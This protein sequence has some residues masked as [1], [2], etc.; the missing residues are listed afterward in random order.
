L[1]EKQ[2]FENPL[3][4]YTRSEVSLPLLIGDRVLGAL[5]VQST[6]TADFGIGVIET[7]ENMASQ[8]AIALE[9]ARLFQ[10]AQNSINELHS[11]QKQ[12]LLKGWSS[13]K[14][15]ND[16]LEYSV[17]EPTDAANQI[18][19][20]AIILRDQSLGKITLERS[21]EWS[22]EQQSLVDAVTAQAAI[23]LENARL[24]SES[25]QIALRERTLSEIN[26]KIWSSTSI[27]SILQTVVKELG[28]RLDTAN[29]TIELK[30][31]DKS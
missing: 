31:D 18:L 5:N 10:E 26:S 24:V 15:Y 28:K 12:Y 25:R 13:I 2:R 21:D 4:P 23:A 7:M 9:N 17:G 3:L 6:K 8:V 1:D 27:E 20:S 19:E 30:M 16:D 11:I 29:T 22:P 14:F